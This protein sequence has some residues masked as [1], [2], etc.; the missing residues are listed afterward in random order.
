MYETAQNFEVF[1]KIQNWELK[2][3]NLY[4]AVDVLFQAYGTTLMQIKKMVLN[5]KLN[6]LKTFLILGYHVSVKSYIS[7]PYNL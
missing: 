3:K 2:I 7:S 4:V 1:S 6:L 5:K